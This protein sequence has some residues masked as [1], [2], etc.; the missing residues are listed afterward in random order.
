MQSRRSIFKLLLLFSITILLGACSGGE[1]EETEETGTTLKYTIGGTVSGLAGSSLTLQ[2]NGGDVFTTSTDG[3]FTFAYPI[4]D[5]GSY[6]VTPLIQP[7]NPNQTCSVSNG[8]GTVSGTN[9]S[10]I[11]VT[12]VTNPST[13]GGTV[14]G[15]A[16]SGLV[17]QNNGGDDLIIN[18][19]GGF[20][21]ATPVAAGGSYNVTVQTQPTSL[22]Q[23]CN[24]SN[25]SGTASGTNIS[26][27]AVTCVTN[28]YTIGGTVSGLAGSGLILRNN[29]KD[30]LTISADG[31]FNFP[32]PITDGGS[33]SV[34]VLTQPTSPRQ[35]CSVSNGV[36]TV[37][38]ANVSNIVIT[39]V[40]NTY[41]IGGTVYG[42]SG[43]GLVLQNNGGDDL[44]ISA[45]GGFT[46]ATPITDSGSYNVTVLTQPASPNQTCTITNGSGTLAGASVINVAVNCTTNTYTI[47]VTVAGL[48]GSGM[49]LQ[50]NG[51]DDLAISADGS[52]TFTTPWPMAVTMRSVYLPSRQI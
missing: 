42:L 12:C 50:N 9:I 52:F 16:G 28:T 24:V 3:S 34:T 47:G 21:F 35:T 1:E 46:F 41:T 15:L 40:T 48:S 51:G 20:T 8:S 31:S 13:V 6:N 33:Y 18:A 36:G 4:A 44:A 19:N 45:N 25:G 30:S 32:T 37:S 7:T 27:I 38:G 39:C 22:N 11:A 10:N 17:L 23:T 26:N 43:S 49:V 5:G 14:Y 2:N 29:L